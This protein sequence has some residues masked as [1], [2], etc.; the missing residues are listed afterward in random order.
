MD[1]QVFNPFLPSWE[2]IPDGEP[3]IFEGRLYLY[4][5]H[6]RFNGTQF[7]MN[8]YVCW[9]CPLEDLSDWRLEGTIYHKSQDPEAG[10]ESIL[11]APD[12]CRGPDGRYYLYYNLGLAP[13]TSVAVCD[14]PAGRYEYYGMVRRKDGTLAGKGERDVFPFDPGLFR[15][16]DGRIWLYT[17]F[18]PKE[19][20]MFAEA[21][22]KFRMEGAYVMELE[23]DMLTLH[24]EP[25]LIFSKEGEHGFFEASSMRKIGDRYYF[26]YS[27]QLGHEL[28][29][30][31]GKG[32]EGPFAYGGTL[33]S[34]GDV[35]L[36]ERPLNYTGN[37]HGS[38]VCIRDQWYVFYHR[39]TNRHQYSRQ[40]C[41]EKIVFEEGRFLQAEL[42][43]CGLNGG[44]LRGH[45]R[46]EARIACH[47][48][49]REGALFYGLAATPEAKDHPYFTQTGEDREGDP[50][51]YIAGM[52]DGA[53][54][55]FR[56]FALEGLEKIGAEVSGSGKGELLVS[57]E[58]EGDPFCRIPVD[59]EGKK[60]MFYGSCPPVSGTASLYFTF[61]GSGSIDFHS[62]VLGE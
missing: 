48:W 58:E 28:C 9:S 29:W 60:Q 23:E 54:A 42:T 2:Y 50:D 53:A 43:S 1:R 51:Q 44:P 55:G 16:D 38:L 22:K 34:N 30:A 3:H 61:R 10:P 41:A 5:S 25:K 12:V 18:G 27:S 31:V 52:Q 49:S 4:G 37:T 39:Q 6:D 20:G 11:Q 8:D 33:V 13:F 46:Y 56:R 15:D 36:S 59:P 24:S 57:L 47:L 7:C 40:A 35:G 17:G 14:T 45:G 26:L 62:F 21:A 19:E 32:P